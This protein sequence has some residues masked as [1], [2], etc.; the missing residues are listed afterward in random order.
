MT[1]DPY[2]E[3]DTGAHVYDHPTASVWVCEALCPTC[4]FHPGNRMDLEPGRVKE[5]LDEAVAAEGHIVCH[6]TLGTPTPAI[7]AGFARHPDGAARS[8]ALRF[9]RAGV[10][11]QTLIDP[12]T[13]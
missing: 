13:H 1:D 5:M 4:I 9:V 2:D 3:W 8:L 11:R 10:L 12:S 7:C 6:S